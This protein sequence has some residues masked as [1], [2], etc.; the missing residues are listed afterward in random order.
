MP[1]N[2]SR[3]LSN[4]N[5][6]EQI[7]SYQFVGVATPTNPGSEQT[8]DYRCFYLA[9]TPG[10]YTYLGGLVV[11]DGEVAL[12]KWNN[13][14]TKELTDVATADSVSQLNLKLAKCSYEDDGE[15]NA[16]LEIADS[17]GKV[18]AR[19][20]DGHFKTKNFDSRNSGGGTIED[21][22]Y[23]D[24]A[25]VDSEN[26]CLLKL[27]E[28]HLKTKNFDS[29]NVAINYKNP[30]SEEIIRFEVEVNVNMLK[31]VNL[32]ADLTDLQILYTDKGLLM[33][34][35]TYTP[36]G[37]PTRLVIACH[38][39]GGGVTDHD[40]QIE[41]QTLYKYLVA[42]GYAVMDMQGMPSSWVET[43]WSDY[44]SHGLPAAKKEY[45]K[46]N[47][48]G[49][50][51]TMECYIKGYQWVIEH[52]NIAQ[53]GIFIAGASMGGLSSMNLVL[54]QKLPIIAHAVFAPVL[55]TY[56]QAFLHPWTDGISKYALS[57]IYNFSVDDND[58]F[59][60]DSAKVCGY[61]PLINGMQTF[62]DGVRIDSTGVY[63][64]SSGKLN[65]QTITEYRGYPC[66]LK[67]WHCN[68]DGTVNI[69]CSIRFINAVKNQGGGAWLRRFPT[70][71]HAPDTAGTVVSNP[72]GNTILH[73]V[74]VGTIYPAAEELLLYF[75]RYNN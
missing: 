30:Y 53:D 51:L 7:E 52:Y 65:G 34:P 75:N 40:S 2:I 49:C 1:Y 26:K 11:N 59:V 36:K 19:F 3:I 28:G 6:N 46:V 37:T 70:G 63:D 71:G 21:Y 64:F 33:L 58:G 4:P 69:A 15:V 55:D 41:N 17:N 66:P 8:P 42:N 29:K 61:N 27:S 13:G 47:N 38:G 67:I 31:D 43:W 32:T 18:L 25:I 10:T 20:S 48:M 23:G 39:A 35:D 54:T 12:L 5:L 73:G 14:W 9:T 16:D 45:V 56:N 24:F 50:P 74:S 72:I 68:D 62:H 44:E 22:I 60:Y 57:K